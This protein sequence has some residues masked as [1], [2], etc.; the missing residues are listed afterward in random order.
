MKYEDGFPI[1]M[2]LESGYFIY[3][4][5]R[6]HIYV[7]ELH[8]RSNSSFTIVGFAVEPQRLYYNYISLKSRSEHHPGCEENVQI[9]DFSSKNLQN[10]SIA[11]NIFFTYDVVFHVTIKF[12]SID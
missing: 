9:S 8:D 11:H 2:K 1:G 12:N 5:L 4:H 10:L 6:L 7:H 3:N